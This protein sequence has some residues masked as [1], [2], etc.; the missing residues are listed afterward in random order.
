MASEWPHSHALSLQSLAK[1]ALAMGAGMLSLLLVPMF[2]A[3][4]LSRVD[5]TYPVRYLT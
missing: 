2:A 1:F 4:L 3:V 5:R